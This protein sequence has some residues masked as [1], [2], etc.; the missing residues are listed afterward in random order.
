MPPFDSIGSALGYGAASGA[1]GMGFGLVNNAVTGLIDNAFY[2]RNLGLQVEAQKNLMDYQ[3]EYNSPTAQMQRLQA[4]GLNPNLVYGSQAP[5]GQSGNASA[6]SGTGFPGKYNT[7]D[8][9][10]AGAHYAQM[11]QAESA[12]NL[13][14]SLAAKAEAEKNYTNLLNGRYNELVD[15]QIKESYARINELSTRSDLNIANANKA[16]AEQ[17]LAEAEA[18]YKAGQLSLIQYEKQRIVAE[19]ALLKEKK[20]TE[21]AQQNLFKEQTATQSQLGDVY[22][23]EAAINKAEAYWQELC[24]SEPNLKLREARMKAEL[25]A[26]TNELNIKG[27]KGVIWVNTVF[28]WLTGASNTALQSASAISQGYSAAKIAG[29]LK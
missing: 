15:M 2:K 3:N 28:G 4:A 22:Y 16:E 1:I 19:T 25:A 14:N 8:I 20:N 21:R 13:N 11:K 5:A 17:I 18:A 23:Y 10:A 7:I 24:S 12:T 26:Q 27:K 9:A 29:A 6:P